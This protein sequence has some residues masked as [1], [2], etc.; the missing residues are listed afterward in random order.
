MD[1][2]V[3]SKLEQ[4]SDEAFLEE[5]IGL[6]DQV[7]V[8]PF[9]VGIPP[10]EQVKRMMNWGFQHG[11][12]FWLLKDQKAHTIMRIALRA[13]PHKK[14][15]G[16]IG[17]FEIDL[18]S[19][20][21][22]EGF[23]FMMKAAEEWFKKQNISEIIAPVDINTWFN[24]RFSLPGPKFFPR[25]KWEPTNPPDYLELFKNFHYQQF[26]HFNSVFFPH[27]KIGHFAPGTGHLK[28]SYERLTKMGYTLRPFDVENFKTKELPAF[29]EISH[30]AFSDSLLFE[31]IDFETFSELYASGK[32]SYDFSPSRVL[33]S[34]EGET[35]G[36]LFAFFD[37]DHYVIK[38]LALKKKFQGLKLSS[39]MVY[40][41]IL[42]SFKQK[43]KAT[44]S[45]LV[46]TGI[47]SD[48]MNGS[49][50]KWTWFAWTHD[51]LLLKKDLKGE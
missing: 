14:G 16:T 50:R 18:Q 43:K 11:S 35:A 36:F 22:R 6:P 12:H 29:Y 25:F 46:R 31:P 48:K 34:P 38:S 1:K 4:F 21:H 24:Y 26:A 28:R 10:A 7:R 17:F 9:N 49:S 51:Y 42:M 44:V 20:L 15:A 19:P 13:C 41:G 47:T 2:F 30:E 45:A 8:A 27:I 39:G 37:G 3:I 23:S 40:P 32:T 33:V 5:F